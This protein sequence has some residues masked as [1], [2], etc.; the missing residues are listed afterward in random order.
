MIAKNFCN[1]IPKPTHKI[2]F[3]KNFFDPK[4]LEKRD[5]WANNDDNESSFGEHA[6]MDNATWVYD[7]L[8]FL[9][10]NS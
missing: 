8:K 1:E 7:S 4:N 5:F 2:F 6:S 3:R 10:W 9:L